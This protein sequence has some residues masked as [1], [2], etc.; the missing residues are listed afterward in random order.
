[1]DASQALAA[2]AALAQDT[3]LQAFRLLVRHEPGGLPAGD[4]GR[5]LGVPQNTMSTHL[6]VLARAGLVRARRR[7]RS[8]IYRAELD[9]VRALNLFLIKDCCGAHPELCRPL[10]ADLQ[11]G[12]A[13][14]RSRA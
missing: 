7:G 13:Q 2:F 12:H 6:A 11:P 4:I 9:A 14:P 1:M 8:M 5:E 3:R 10:L